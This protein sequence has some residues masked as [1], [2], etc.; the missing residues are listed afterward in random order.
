M[1]LVIS[2]ILLV[3]IAFSAQFVYPDFTQ[4]YNKNKKSFVYLG[5][6]RAIAVGKHTA[7]AY[8]KTKPH[9]SFVKYD[10]FLNLYMFH[11]KKTLHPV[12]LKST[13]Y[14]K[15]GE[16][17]GGMDEDSLF[18]GNFAKSGDVL[19][20]IYLQNTSLK[21]NSIISC[22]CCDVYGLGVGKGEFIGSEYIKR[23]INAK[24]VF[25]G[26][27]GARFIQ[28]DGKFYVNDIDPFYKK[29]SLKVGDQILT[30]NNKKVSSLKRL[31]QAILFAK[32]KSTIRLKVKRG[33]KIAIY[34]LPI[35]A[36]KGGGDVQDSFL[37]RKGLFLDN[38]MKIAKIQPHSFAAK[39]GLKVG[40][41]L[42]QVNHKSTTSILALRAILSGLKNKELELLFDR[43][44][45]QFFVTLPR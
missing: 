7:I 6:L 28:K 22:L 27:I 31:N 16:W 21:P 33:K 3:Q 26:D 8:S 34:V 25:Y 13:H 4:C 30:V 37:E 19:N 14:L 36:R 35:V 44:D 17:I 39:Q 12:R 24:K 40:D 18:V 41:K 38:N 23:F 32:P 2:F 10:P 1:R 20:S 45:F 5:S 11:T 15:V 29:N 9:T 42:L 43:N